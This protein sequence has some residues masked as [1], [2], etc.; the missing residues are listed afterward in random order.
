MNPI[1]MS[2]ANHDKLFK[3]LGGEVNRQK[4]YCQQFK[5][6]KWNFKS[7]VPGVGFVQSMGG[8]LC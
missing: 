3:Q 5:G 6:S 8:R 4:S 7:D 2:E 1:N